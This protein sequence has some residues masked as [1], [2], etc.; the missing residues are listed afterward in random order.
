MELNPEKYSL[1]T[2]IVAQTAVGTGVRKSRYVP[3]AIDV[4]K[5]ASRSSQ[6]EETPQ[7]YVTPTPRQVC[8]FP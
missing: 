4:E 1:K 7:Q 5:S 6:Q 2:V 8:I 3:R